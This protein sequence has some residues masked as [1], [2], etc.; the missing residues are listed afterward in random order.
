M[1]NKLSFPLPD[2]KDT[3]LVIVDVQKRLMSAM[4]E[5]ISNNTL[6]NIGVLITS[7]NILNIPIIHT[8]QYP[9]GLGKTCP[10]IQNLLQNHYPPVEKLSLSCCEVDTFNRQVIETG[11]KQ[12]ILTG[13]EAHVCVFQTAL[14]LLQQGYTIYLV[15]DAVCSR[16]KMDWQTSLDIAAKAGALI[17][18]TEIILFQIL[19]RAGTEEFK[20]IQSLLK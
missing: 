4:P 3:L 15:K 16:H 19:G 17:T 12:I 1:L 5:E 20:H 13:V 14:D 18:A 6:N 7:A 8:E 2:R 11:K 9:K 10:Q